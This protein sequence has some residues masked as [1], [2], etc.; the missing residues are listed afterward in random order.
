MELIL[1]N[2]SQIAYVERIVFLIFR[3]HVL[4]IK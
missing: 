4:R 1:K 2:R 3:V